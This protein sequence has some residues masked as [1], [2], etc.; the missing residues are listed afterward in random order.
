MN[1][2]LKSFPLEVPVPAHEKLKD[3]IAALRM[4]Q[5]L[6]ITLVDPT[7]L[8]AGLRYHPE[9]LTNSP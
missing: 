4:F 1:M 9:S 2:I 3:F 8:F 6:E 7:R 5:S